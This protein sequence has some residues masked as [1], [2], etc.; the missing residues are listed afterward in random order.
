MKQ[1][2]WNFIINTFLVA[3]VGS[4]RLA[5][6]IAKDHNDALFA[7]KADPEINAMYLIFHPIYLSMQNAYDLWHAQGGTQ[8]GE[9]LG[10]NLLM[11]QLSHTKIS[12]WDIDIQ[13][14]YKRKTPEYKKL[15]PHNRTPFQIG[16][17]D[18]R[19]TAVAALSKNLTGI[20]ALT[21]LKTDVDA[22]KIEL[23]TGQDVK[24]VSFKTTDNH[25]EAVEEARVAMCNKMFGNYGRL[26][27]IN[28]DNPSAITKYFP[29][30]FIHSYHQIFFMHSIKP[31]AKYKV[32][33]H[34]FLPTD[35]LWIS[36]TSE[37]GFRVYIS[38]GGD[39][40]YSIHGV[41]IVGNTSVTIEAALL[42]NIEANKYLM[43]QNLSHTNNADF[44]IEF[45]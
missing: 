23:T 37:A 7:G 1:L 43:V 16:S 20:P 18:N 34:T 29:I 19:I 41:V 42:G 26:L 35:E 15:L 17:Q 11:K 12:D 5:V 25:S 33:K 36:A 22:F 8:S 44:E 30:K 6:R 14:I 13:A 45:L 27:G 9:T 21:A 10:L 4:Y 24:N 39:G 40:D 31:D 32:V 3:T 2:T 28:E 38:D